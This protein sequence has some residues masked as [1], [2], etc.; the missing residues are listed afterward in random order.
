MRYHFIPFRRDVIKKRRDSKC[1]QDME[2]KERLYTIGGNVNQCSHMK[3]SME[4]PRNIKSRILV[5]SSNPISRYI[6]KENEI[7]ISKRYLQPHVQCS[8][9]YSSKDKKITQIYVYRR[10]D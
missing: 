5:L 9:I 4:D 6:P 2:N 3:N 8:T 7:N 1:W 10:L